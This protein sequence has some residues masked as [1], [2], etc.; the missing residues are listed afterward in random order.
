MNP[1]KII[2]KKKIKD[3]IIREINI[4]IDYANGDRVWKAL[5]EFIDLEK[6]QTKAQCKKQFLEMIENVFKER[7]QT[8]DKM[9]WQNR[10]IEELKQ[11]VE[12]L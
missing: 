10:F 12:K 11:Q 3:D 5:D 2:S 8:T 9:F 4:G 6:A 1:S 7:K